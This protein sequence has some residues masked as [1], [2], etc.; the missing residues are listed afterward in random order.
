MT[1]NTSI[2]LSD[3]FATFVDTQVQAGRFGSVS[4]VIRAGLRPL[5]DQETQREAL[6][7]PLVAG[8]E[9]GPSK[10]FDFDTFSDRTPAS[11]SS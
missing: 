1:R 6:R 4:D 5:E 9:S 7:A 10:P 2:F 3:H 8:E 11:P